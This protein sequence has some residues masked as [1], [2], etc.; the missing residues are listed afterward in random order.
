MSTSGGDKVTTAHQNEGKTPT[1]EADSPDQLRQEIE[2]TRAELGDT[3]EALAAKADVK[4]QVKDKL[5]ATKEDV[6]EKVTTQAAAVKEKVA[7]AIPEPVKE[8]VT[9]GAAQLNEKVAARTEPL[10][11]NLSTRIPEPAR[12]AVASVP[13][14]VRSRPLPA[15]LSAVGLLFVWRMIRRRGRQ[16]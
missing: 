7:G 5:D 14:P 6:K 13:E 10:R 2:Q 16:R 3:V 1:G 11:E 4:A 15:V 12:Q 9:S 8:K